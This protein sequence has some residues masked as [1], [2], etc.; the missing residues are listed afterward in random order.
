MLREARSGA[1]VTQAEL[2]RRMGVT[3]PMVAAYESGTREPSL[4]TFRRLIRAL[5][6]HVTLEP[7]ADTGRLP[8]EE[9]A[10]ELED[11]LGLVDSLP[12][13]P[14]DEPLRFPALARR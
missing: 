12:F 2:A 10:R 13:S 3:Q 5:G 7:V 9:A 14:P 4:A 6:L 8:P 1:G 11:V